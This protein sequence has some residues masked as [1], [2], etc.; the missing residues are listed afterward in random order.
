MSL[1]NFHIVLISLSS[2]LAFL[3]GGWSLHAARAGES[4]GNLAAGLLSILAGAGLILYVIWFA[5]KIYTTEEEQRRRRK[6]IRPLAL[7]VAVW[8][9]GTR[10]AG[11]CSVCYGQADDPMIDGARIGVFLLFGLVFLVQIA[12]VMFFLYLRRRAREAGNPL[13]S[14]WPAER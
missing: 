2:L 13:V 3:F 6:I 4:G 12:F 1:K 9:L 5:R 7:P 11:A 10:S 8:M 14:P